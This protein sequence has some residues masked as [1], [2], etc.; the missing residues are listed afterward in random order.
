MSWEQE[1]FLT[2]EVNIPS[3]QKTN[4][5]WTR[6]L[7]DEEVEGRIAYASRSREWSRQPSSGT[8]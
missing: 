6:S 1:G 2:D 8:S 7:S 4:D 5:Y 3:M